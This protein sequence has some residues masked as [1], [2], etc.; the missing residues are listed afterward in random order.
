MSVINFYLFPIEL[1]P[2]IVKIQRPFMLK[3]CIFPQS[4]TNWGGIFKSINYEFF[5]AYDRIDM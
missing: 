5:Y 2:E 4:L 1:K 3:A